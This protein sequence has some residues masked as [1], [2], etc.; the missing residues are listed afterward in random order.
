ML[1]GTPGSPDVTELQKQ[2]MMVAD[3]GQVTVPQGLGASAGPVVEA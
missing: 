2:Q 1:S 3:G